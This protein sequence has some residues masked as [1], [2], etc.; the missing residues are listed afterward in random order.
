M[1][2]RNI[3]WIMV[4]AV[5]AL[6]LWQVPEILIRRDALYKQF[7]PLV[8]VL[9]QVEK[10]YV[11]NPEPDVLLHGAIDGM[12]SRLDPYSQYFRRQRNTAVPEEHRGRICRHRDRRGPRGRRRDRGGVADRRV[13]SVRAGLR[14]S[15]RILKINGKST[16]TLKINDA[17]DLID[18]KPGTSVSLLMDRPGHD[19]PFKCT[20]PPAHH[21]PYRARLGALGRLGLGLPHRP[22]QGHRLR[23]HHRIQE[24]HRGAV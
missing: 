24:A 18:G 19:A 14:A 23:A 20:S 4:L 6:L 2:K 13:A 5:I 16:L 3:V 1:P 21:R 17:I 15:D 10:N 11:D 9:F 22:C 8:D 12:L 7:S